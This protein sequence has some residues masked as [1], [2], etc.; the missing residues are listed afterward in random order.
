MTDTPDATVEIPAPLQGCL[1]CHNEGTIGVTDGRKILGLGSGLPTLTCRNCGSVARFEP[2]P[3]ADNW[4][5]RYR[6]F[7]KSPRFY[8]VI[9]YLGKAGWLTADEALAISH[10]GCV[11]HQRIQQ[12]QRADLN[13]VAPVPL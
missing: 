2:G 4:R 9:L 6:T 7:N 3:D 11:Q 12:V 1:Y 5:I 13:S 10:N 8:Y